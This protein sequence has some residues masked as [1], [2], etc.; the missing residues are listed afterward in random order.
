MRENIHVLILLSDGDGTEHGSDRPTLCWMFGPLSWS[1][2]DAFAIDFVFLLHTDLTCSQSNKREAK[3]WRMRLK[4]RGQRMMRRTGD[5]ASWHIFSVLVY[6]TAAEASMCVCVCA[7]SRGLCVWNAGGSALELN[8]RRARWSAVTGLHTDYI[9]RSAAWTT[10]SQPPPGVGTPPGKQAAQ[11]VKD[12]EATVPTGK[13]INGP[14]HG[15][16]HF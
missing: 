9:P 4:W 12:M 7:R 3:R 2:I 10:V 13:W 15:Q 14:F 5:G 1:L 11:P 8:W 6:L 16:T